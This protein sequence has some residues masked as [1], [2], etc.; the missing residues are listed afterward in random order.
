MTDIPA[1][2]LGACLLSVPG[3]PE[4]SVELCIMQERAKQWNYSFVDDW[5]DERRADLYRRVCEFD[6]K[7]KC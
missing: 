3:Q 7:R 2:V 1:Y 6:R 4:L 5:S